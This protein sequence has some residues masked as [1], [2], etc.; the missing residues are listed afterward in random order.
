MGN[1]Y[2]LW[3]FGDNVEDELGTIGFFIF[4]ARYL[5]GFYLF[6]DILYATAGLNTGIA[7]ISHISGALI[8]IVWALYMQKNENLNPS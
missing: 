8:G 2:F 7:Y 3:T 1:M 4:P 5:I 6:W